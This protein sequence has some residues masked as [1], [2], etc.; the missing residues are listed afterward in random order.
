LL[1]GET[2]RKIN[3]YIIA[4]DAPSLP[5]LRELYRGMRGLAADD[6]LR[7]SHEDISRTLDLEMADGSTVGAGVRIFAE[8][9]LVETGTDDDGRFIRFVEVPGKVDLTQTTRFAEGEAER[10]NF[11]RFCGLALGADAQTL[12]QIINR[13]IYPDRVPFLN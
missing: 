11:D 9:G 2:D 8:G 1:Y 4:R 6:V 5:L 10:E 13:P 3:D 7:L 12:E